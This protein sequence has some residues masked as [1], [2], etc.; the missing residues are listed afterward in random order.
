[1]SPKNLPAGT[2][3]IKINISQSFIDQK[4]T[5]RNNFLGLAFVAGLASV[6][7]F[8]VHEREA[9]ENRARRNEKKIIEEPR[10]SE[11]DS[12]DKIALYMAYGIGLVSAGSLIVAGAAQLSLREYENRLLELELNALPPQEDTPK[13]TP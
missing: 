4:K 9:E 11:E 12:R 10:P 6:F 3:E 8:F 5:L 1:M 2:M 7:L 13:P